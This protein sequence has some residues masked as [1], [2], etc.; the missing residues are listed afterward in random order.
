MLIYQS[1]MS[2]Y[3]RSELLPKPIGK[4]SDARFRMFSPTV[5]SGIRALAGRKFPRF[6]RNTDFSAAGYNNKSSGTAR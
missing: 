2:M 1:L 3:Q 5:K 6:L 4:N